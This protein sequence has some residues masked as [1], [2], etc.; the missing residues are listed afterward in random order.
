MTPR[1]QGRA[2]PTPT[3]AHV[4]A[5]Y[6]EELR[7]AG[8]SPDEVHELVLIAARNMGVPDVGPLFLARAEP[9]V[10][11]VWI[12]NHEPGSPEDLAIRQRLGLND[13]TQT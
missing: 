5:A 12:E 2:T 10:P 1:F 7:G 8:F 3:T 11:I 4:L 6:R 9:I 13:E